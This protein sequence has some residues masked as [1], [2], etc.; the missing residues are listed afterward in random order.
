M[1]GRNN[2]EQMELFQNQM[3]TYI[4]IVSLASQLKIDRFTTFQFLLPK[5]HIIKK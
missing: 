5:V 2:L 1:N 4:F 3:E